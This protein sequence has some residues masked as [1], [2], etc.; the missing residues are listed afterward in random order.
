MFMLTNV[1]PERESKQRIEPRRD[2]SLP[3]S[4]NWATGLFYLEPEQSRGQ[5]L[6]FIDD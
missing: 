2:K 5:R 1:G 3:T 4:T 6:I